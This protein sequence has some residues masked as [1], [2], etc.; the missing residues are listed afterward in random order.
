MK[1]KKRLCYIIL[2]ISEMINKGPCPYYLT[3]LE[4]GGGGLV[5]C[6]LPIENYFKMTWFFTSS[7]YRHPLDSDGTH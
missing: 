6:I 4:G 5:D 1:G 3:T 7:S 2:V